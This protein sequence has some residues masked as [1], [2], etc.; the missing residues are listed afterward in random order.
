MDSLEM[1]WVFFSSLDFVPEPD[2][3]YSTHY[4]AKLKL[5]PQV[6]V[7]YFWPIASHFQQVHIFA[8][9]PLSPLWD[10]GI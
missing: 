1:A 5:S 8:H 10:T 7:M 9:L 4:K 6:A 2:I 3:C